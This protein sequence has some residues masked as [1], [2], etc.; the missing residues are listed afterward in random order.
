MRYTWFGS[1][2]N[3]EDRINC[4]M[5]VIKPVII[6]VGGT[7]WKNLKSA[8]ENPFTLV[9][10]LSANLFKILCSIN[11]VPPWKVQWS[12][13]SCVV[14]ICYLRLLIKMPNIKGDNS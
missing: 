7:S 1:D 10:A 4:Y 14:V 13:F 5:D 2:L 12:K 9:I 3:L 8:N 6:T 11:K